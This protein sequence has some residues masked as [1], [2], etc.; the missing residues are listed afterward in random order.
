MNFGGVYKGFARFPVTVATRKVNI[1]SV[2]L[3]R[4]RKSVMGD[5]ASRGSTLSVREYP[6]ARAAANQRRRKGIVPKEEKI[7]E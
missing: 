6:V 1:A 2:P 5:L 7:Y 4:N 3:A